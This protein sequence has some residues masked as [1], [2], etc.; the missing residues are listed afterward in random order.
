MRALWLFLVPLTANAVTP[1]PVIQAM[2]AEVARTMAGL[3]EEVDAPYYVALEVVEVTAPSAR[4]EDGALHDADV[5]VWRWVDV[6]VRVGSPMLD[7]S[8][9]LRN[10]REDS[11][12]MARGR[13]VPITDDPMRLRHELWLAIDDAWKA[14]RER[15]AQVQT[16]QRT[17]V[18][19]QPAE[20]LVQMAPV[21]DLQSVLDLSFD[22]EAWADPVR[23]AS[24]VFADSPHVLEGAASIGGDATTRWFVDSAGT[25]LRTQ[26][27]RLR[28]TL[29]VNGRADDGTDVPLSRSWSSASV[30]G[31]PSEEELTAGAEGLVSDLHSLLAA[32][33]QGPWT[34]PAILSDRAAGVFFH[35][36]FGHR[37]EGHRLKRVDNAQTFRE[38][39]GEPILPTFLSVVDDPTLARA[40]STDLRGFYAY[41]NQGVAAERVVLVDHGVLQGF[42]QSRS[43]TDAGTPSNGHGRRQTGRAAVSRQGNLMVEAHEHV[44]NEELRLKLIEQVKEQG[45]DYG[46]F[47]DEIT[48]GFTFTGRSSPAAFKVKAV[49]AWRVYADGRPDELVRGA[50]LVGTPLEAFAN[51][52]AAGEL[53]QVFNGSCGAES[54]WV[55]VSAVSPSVLVKRVEVQR[56]EQGQRMPP[57]LP[58]PLATKK[59]VGS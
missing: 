13:R 46:L 33:V 47:I 14:S 38:R 3:S 44:T 30:D 36:V 17:L 19:E 16:E 48:G 18:E 55:P 54:G 53:E 6:D 34:G 32:P 9:A 2:E 58:A 15:W 37:V 20:D 51:I 52:L 50:D 42:L 23:H 21:V 41:D 11:R 29:S 8:H 7:S 57:L 45:L 25:K 10:T 59:E 4:A 40:A 31:L 12:T 43:P 39:V 24:A 28:A 22:P 1:D 56:K 26:E 35:E 49:F 5:D 27:V